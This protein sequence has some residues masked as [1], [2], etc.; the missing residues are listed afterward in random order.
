MSAGQA[1]QLALSFGP[2]AGQTPEEL[3]QRVRD[4]T[5]ELLAKARTQW[6]DARLPDPEIRFRL[7][8]RTAGEACP[9]TALTNYNQELLEK[10]GEDFIREIVP[11]ELAHLIAPC[12]HPHRIRPHG[13]EWKAVMAFFGVP[14]KRCHTFETMPVASAGR[15]RY[16]CACEK[17]HWLTRRQHRR[18]QRGHMVYSC[19]ACGKT[20]VYVK[21]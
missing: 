14:A 5:A 4:V 6:P 18:R 19:R 8:G 16:H 7:R 15:F 20:L 12:L 1:E 21:G 17:D 2:P 3:Q 10:Y 11:H 9:R 13:K